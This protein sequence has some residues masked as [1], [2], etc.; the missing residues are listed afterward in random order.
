MK[1]RVLGS[2]AGGGFP[3]WNCGCDNCREVRRGS[4]RLRARTEESIVVSADSRSWFLVN[5][6]PDVRRQF[7]SFP[8]LEPGTG[9]GCPVDGIVLTNGDLDHCLG[10]LTLRESEP[11]TIYATSRVR[12]GFTQGNVLYRTLERF[13]GQVTWRDLPLGRPISLTT[14][15]GTDSGLSIEAVA[16]PGKL[17]IHLEGKVAPSAEDNVGLR[18]RE[19][20]TGR[21]LA[22]LPAVAG[23]NREIDHLATADCIFFDGTF[24]SD[25]E[26]SRQGLGAKRARDMAH[27]P[28]GGDEG[29]LTFLGTKGGRRRVLIHINNTNPMLTEDSAEASAVRAAG[30]EIA[31]DGMEVDI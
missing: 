27:W 21:T 1:V 28:V 17:P 29:S 31:Y 8:A 20:S 23:P 15:D 26:L 5:A 16:V 24:W 14:R 18:I 19:E 9:R 7:E 6:S 11:L 12:D 10:L 2:A 3:Q 30:V 22:Y 13:S 25:D 4:P